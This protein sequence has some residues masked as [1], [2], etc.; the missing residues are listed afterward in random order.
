M[1]NIGTVN[2]DVLK[3]KPKNELN[4]NIHLKILHV[5][6]YVTQLYHNPRY[7]KHKVNIELL[8]LRGLDQWWN[9]CLP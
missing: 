2:K 1:K 8:F 5:L 7:K 3:P 9:I 6:V 4:E